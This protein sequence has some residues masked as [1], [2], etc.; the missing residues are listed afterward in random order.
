[1][2]SCVNFFITSYSFF[3]CSIRTAEWYSFFF[4]K[5]RL[6]A[7]ILCV[8]ISFIIVTSTKVSIFICFNDSNRNSVLWYCELFFSNENVCKDEVKNV[9]NIS[10]CIARTSNC[11]NCVFV[12]WKILIDFSMYFSICWMRL[13]LRAKESLST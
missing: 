13:I 3:T 1:M 4:K 8:E 6:R 10:F 5:N 11:L 2:C 12:L 7:H 9:W